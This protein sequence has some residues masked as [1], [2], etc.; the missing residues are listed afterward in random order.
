M[1]RNEDYLYQYKYNPELARK[2]ASGFMK[3]F[4]N[5]EDVEPVFERNANLAKFGKKLT[6]EDIP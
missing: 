5:I 3:M 2:D 6:D 1:E 4:E